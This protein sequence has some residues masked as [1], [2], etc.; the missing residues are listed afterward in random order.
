MINC[1]EFGYVFYVYLYEWVYVESEVFIFY[2]DK[3][4]FFYIYFIEFYIV[5][6]WC[7]KNVFD[8]LYLFGIF[9]YI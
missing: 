6:Y 3:C 1:I 8:V 2:L 9:F 4:Y 5:L 7:F